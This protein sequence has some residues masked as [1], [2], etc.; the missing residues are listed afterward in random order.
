MTE[1]LGEYAGGHG[2]PLPKP[3]DAGPEPPGLR[4]RRAW[5]TTAFTLMTL[6][7]LR[8]RAAFSIE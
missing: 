6:G 4:F 8:L 5:P 1:V 2:F 3:V 7:R